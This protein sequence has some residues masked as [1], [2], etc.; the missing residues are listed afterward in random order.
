MQAIYSIV[1]MILALTTPGPHETPKAGA[2][3]VTGL[4]AHVPSVNGLPQAAAAAEVAAAA[5]PSS[6]AAALG[7][8]SS[9]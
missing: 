9:A 3:V 5:T 1:V 2:T 6:P 8:A 4:S 7:Q